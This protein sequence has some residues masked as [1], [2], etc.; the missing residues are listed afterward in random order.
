MR[1]GKESFRFP[2]VV[3]AA[4]VVLAVGAA[5]AWGE[6][7]ERF[8]K[9][10][11]LALD[12]KVILSNV[13]GDIKISTWDKAQVKIEALKSGR[14]EEAVREVAI[15]VSGDGRI[16]RVETKY[17]KRRGWGS[18]SGNVSVDFTLV[19]PAQAAIDATSVSG[20]VSL[21]AIGGAVRAKSVSGDVTLT[22]AGAGAECAS[23]SGDV[24][25][26]D[27]K[28]GLDAGSVSGDV[29][30]SRVEGSVDATSV[31]GDVELRHVLGA[32]TVK[33][34]TVSGDVL[35]EGLS[36]PKGRYHL[37]SHSGDVTV[38]LPG[39]AAFELEAG[40]F[41]GDIDS[42]FEIKVTGKM[43]PRELHGTVNGGGP[44]VTVKSFSGSILLRAAGRGAK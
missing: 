6:H 40:T 9:T 23:V 22:K 8:D 33:A 16:V 43:S 42:N 14:N 11:D 21:E 27:V 10:L 15:E 29:I 19:I 39:E 12:G 37:E 5:G 26:A 17:P 41:S 32:D 28:G 7:E 18:D 3:G 36:V 31:S 13:S 20:D 25:V 24:E 38:D 1:H 2:A 34:K 4:L 44:L 30:A 35:F